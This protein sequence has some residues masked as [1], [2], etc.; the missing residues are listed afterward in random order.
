[1]AR[2]WIKAGGVS[3]AITTTSYGSQDSG[4]I[5]RDIVGL[6]EMNCPQ[7][8]FRLNILV[9]KTGEESDSKADFSDKNEWKKIEAKDKTFFDT[10]CKI[11]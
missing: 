4:M 11:K 9:G 10:V 5:R 1:M 6:V 8:T 2:V 3:R 7:E